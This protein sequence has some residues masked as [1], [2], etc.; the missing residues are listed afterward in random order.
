M[1]AYN[2]YPVG[3]LFRSSPFSPKP[4]QNNLAYVAAEH[5][6]GP[7]YQIICQSKIPITALLSVIILGKALSIRQWISLMALTFGVGLVQICG[8]ESTD[9]VGEDRRR[10]YVCTAVGLLTCRWLLWPSLPTWLISIQQ[11][12]LLELPLKIPST[13]ST[14]EGTPLPLESP[15]TLCDPRVRWA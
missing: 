15:S 3:T 6:D 11:L 14:T 7:T 4:L 8:S 13:L 2:D 5:L 10:R 12:V 9:K 1:R